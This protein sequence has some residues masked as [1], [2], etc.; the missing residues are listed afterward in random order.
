MSTTTTDAMSIQATTFSNP[1]RAV[2]VEREM[3]RARKKAR[4]VGRRVRKE[5]GRSEEV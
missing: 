3:V 2:V 1:S 5:R 4:R